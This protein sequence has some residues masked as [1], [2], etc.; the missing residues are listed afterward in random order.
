V[1]PVLNFGRIEGKIDAADARQRQNFLNYQQ[2]V[3]QALENMEDALSN[4]GRETVRYSSLSDSV[5][6]NRKATDLAQ[7]QYTGGFTSLLDV[8]VAQRDLLTAES[9]QA[10]SDA[11]LRKDLVS[12]YTAAGGGWQDKQQPSRDVANVR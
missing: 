12:I 4:Y 8:L 5:E 11:N 6:Q 3:L 7:Q 1:Q 2:A 9:S 10:E